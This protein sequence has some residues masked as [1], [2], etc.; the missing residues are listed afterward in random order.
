M[1]RQIR[2]FAT[3]MVCMAMALCVSCKKDDDSSDSGGGNGGGNTGG[4]GGSSQ[5]VE[6]RISKMSFNVVE[7][8]EESTDGGQT[9][10]VID[11][12]SVQ[13][14]MIF[15]WNN[16]LLSKWEIAGDYVYDFRYDNN[17]LSN[18]IWTNMNDGRIDTVACY[19]VEYDGDNM[20]EVTYHEKENGHDYDKVYHLEYSNG[21]LSSVI[22]EHVR[23]YF[24][25]GDNLSEIRSAG[26]GDG[27]SFLSYDDKKN[28]FYGIDAFLLISL[29]NSA[30]MY[31]IIEEVCCLS[32]SKNNCNKYE[33]L[34]EEWMTTGTNDYTYND[35]NYPTQ[36]VVNMIISNPDGYHRLR[37]VR[38]YTYEYLD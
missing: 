2:L 24:W 27:V 32:L 9:W 1:K 28:P 25:N 8:K 22:Y 18:A 26:Y 29:D 36:A 12:D 6:M 19:D 21:K 38:T 16:N 23:N 11:V 14:N 31:N 5:T 10:N 15:T 13:A 4:G 37:D 30:A 20:S 34:L 35:K 33:D 7:Y 3:V 17:K